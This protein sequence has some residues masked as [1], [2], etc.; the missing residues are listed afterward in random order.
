ME[1]TLA[2]LGIDPTAL[3]PAPDQPTR[4][5]SW[6]RIDIRSAARRRCSSCRALAVATCVTR[7]AGHGPCWLDQCR[8]CMIAGIRLSWE[9]GPPTGGRFK[10]TLLAGGRP[11]M[12]GWWEEYATADRKCREWVR[13]HGGS[14]GAQVVLT[15]EE[16][17]DELTRWPHKP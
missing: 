16:T 1:E 3:E 14:A 10:V 11:V 13:A 6:P 12:E 5:D 15:D 9:V 2:F 7:P 17:G 8:D 4:A